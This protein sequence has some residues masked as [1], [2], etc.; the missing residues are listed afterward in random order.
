M[1]LPVRCANVPLFSITYSHDII[2]NIAS[3]PAGLSQDSGETSS[4]VILTNQDFLITVDDE[5]LC[6]APPPAQ[7]ILKQDTR[8][9]RV[10]ISHT[11][12]CLSVT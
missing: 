5:A 3:C 1:E 10:K 12:K 7:P 2:L 4:S 8:K 11:T 9:K 6:P